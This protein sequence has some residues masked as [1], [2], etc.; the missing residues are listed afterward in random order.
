MEN[1][2]VF[3]NLCVPTQYCM[4][5]PISYKRI[6]VRALIVRRVQHNIRNSV[7]NILQNDA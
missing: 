2:A 6:T 4:S 3:K 7:D 5:I 1:V